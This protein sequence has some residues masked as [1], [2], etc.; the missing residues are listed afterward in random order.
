MLCTEA[1]LAS[2]FLFSHDERTSLAIFFEGY[3]LSG[4]RF[5][6][7]RALIQSY[8]LGPDLGPPCLD[9]VLGGP[10]RVSRRGTAR[11]VARASSLFP[12]VLA[13]PGGSL[14]NIWR[15]NPPFM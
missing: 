15:G 12:E 4:H 11:N 2:D 14:V 13:Q 8:V 1:P 3:P 6:R 5:M 10:G 9:P 7:C